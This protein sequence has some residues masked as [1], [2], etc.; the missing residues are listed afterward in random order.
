MRLTIDPVRLRRNIATRLRHMRYLGAT[1]QAVAYVIGWLDGIASMLKPGR[2][3]LQCK[4]IAYRLSVKL[5][6]KGA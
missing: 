1:G 3:A 2:D 6:K 4:R 5:T